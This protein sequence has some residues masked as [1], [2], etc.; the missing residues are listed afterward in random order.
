MFKLCW[1]CVNVILSLPASFAK[2]IPVSGGLDSQIKL[3]LD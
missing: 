1:W 2:R 3:L